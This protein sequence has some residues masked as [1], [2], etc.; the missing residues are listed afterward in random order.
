M[1][2]RDTMISTGVP[3][4]DITRLDNSETLSALDD[5]CRHWGFFQVVGHGVG[6]DVISALQGAMAEFFQLPLATKNRVARSRNNHWGFYDSELTKN[7]PD[8]KEVYDYGPA[9][10][11]ELCPQWPEGL[12]FFQ[13]AILDYYAACEQLCIKLLGAIAQNLGTSPAEL[14]RPFERGHTSYVRLN[15]YPPCPNSNTAKP[16]GISPHTDAGALTCLLQDQ[17]AGLE[18]FN[19]DRWQLVEPRQD[20]LVIN[21]GDIVQVW[22]ND[23][24]KAALHRVVTNSSNERY[25]APFFMNPAYALD[26]QP[27]ASVVDASH[28][29]I[30]GPINWGEFRALRADGDYGD[31]GEEVQIG[32]YRI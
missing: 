5:A 27:L 18:V 16:L 10:G 7:T 26:Y 23:R 17:Q 32:Q 24:Y 21:I 15:Y 20:A 31:Y 29:P 22:S 6:A 28:P 11:D 1:A 8:W 3:V 30:Y 12:P 9:E 19:N 25:S 13:R 4:I 2:E 14:C